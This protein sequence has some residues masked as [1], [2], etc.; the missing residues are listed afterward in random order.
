[1]F[2]VF[3]HSNVKVSVRQPIYSVSQ[4]IDCSKDNFSIELIRK[5]FE[6][7][8]FQGNL[9]VKQPQIIPNLIVS[10][11]DHAFTFSIEMGSSSSTQ[12]LHDVLETDLHPSALFRRVNLGALDNDSVGGK[13]HTP[14]ECGCRYQ[15]VQVSVS[16]QFLNQ[17]SVRSRQTCVMDTDTVHQQLLQ[18]L[19]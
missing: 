8:A 18:V 9:Q 5:R 16:E 4:V 19:T 17:V 7:L 3:Q 13:V 11:N 2:G 15:N 1:M 14:S 6:H 10:S 12:H